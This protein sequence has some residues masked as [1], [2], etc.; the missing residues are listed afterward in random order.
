[1]SSNFY[2]LF[3]TS[4]KG[5]LIPPRLQNAVTGSQFIAD[6][7]NLNGSAREANILNEFLT[8][9]IP[10]FLRDFC[11]V[12]VTMSDASITYLVSSDYLS[13]GSDD[14]YVR[15]PMNPLTAQE[16]A[17]K[18]DCS[19]PTKKMVDDIWRQSD[20]KLNPL[21]WGPPYDSSMMSTER[22]KIH[23]S[24][25]QSQ[26]LNKNG[27]ISGHKKD[28]VLTN[29]LHPNNPAKRV[30]I[31]GWIQSDGKPIQGLNPLSHED[32]Y[33][34]Y[35]H[36]IRLIFNDVMVNGNLM[37]IQDVFKDTKLS[38]LISNEGVLNFTRY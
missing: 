1:M 4:S 12:N 16:I 35:S 20:K 13:I 27:L 33:A 7:I 26:L 32:T 2:N 5:S 11:P 14:D 28:V 38:A 37:R 18:Y 17:D 8:G 25:I 19:L 36:G 21:P 24:R 9:N 10:D 29:R 31:Y 3:G 22:I 15:V 30:A 34:D 23:N 6:N